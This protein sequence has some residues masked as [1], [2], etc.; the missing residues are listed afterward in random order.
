MEVIEVINI[1]LVQNRGTGFERP[2]GSRSEIS[3]AVSR[4]K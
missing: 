3:F 2:K 4:V 1:F